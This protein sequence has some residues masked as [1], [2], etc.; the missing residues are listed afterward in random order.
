MREYSPH[1]D[2][3]LFDGLPD[4]ERLELEPGH[5]QIH[6]LFLRDRRHAEPFVIF[7]NHEV[8]GDQP[9]Q[10]FAKRAEP[11]R[12]SCPQIFEAKPRARREPALQDVASNPREDIRRDGARGLAFSAPADS[13][14]NEKRMTKNE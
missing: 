4:A 7:E 13:R 5:R 8:V 3:P 12:V 10:R 9:H 14:H 1:T 2:R 11:R 6:E